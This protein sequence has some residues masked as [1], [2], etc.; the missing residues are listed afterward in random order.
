MT[1][2]DEHDFPNDESQDDPQQ[3]NLPED[4]QP[5]FMPEDNDETNPEIAS[6]IS[7]DAEQG[8]WLN[9]ALMDH[10]DD[11]APDSDEDDFVDMSGLSAPDDGYADDVPLEIHDDVDTPQLSPEPVV[12]IQASS[13]D[14]RSFEEL[15]LA[16]L[17]GQLLRAPRRTFRAVS[18]VILTP[19]WG[20]GRATFTSPQQPLSAPQ[21]P[22]VAT[23][24]RSVGFL[25]EV[26][27]PKTSTEIQR[28]DVQ[29][30]QPV[31]SAR[32]LIR[33][34][35]Y[36]IAF[37]LAW[38]G[39]NVF[40]SGGMMNRSESNQLAKGVPFLIVAFAIW[41]GAEAFYHWDGLRNW[42]ANWRSRETQD[43][44]IAPTENRFASYREDVP[45][46]RVALMSGA[47]IFA[48]LTWIGTSN[49]SFSFMGFWS[50]CISVFLIVLAMLPMDWTLPE[51]WT[52][53]R[54]A[55]K[56]P[57]VTV[58]PTLIAIVVI[59]CIGGYFRFNHFDSVPPEMTSD[60]VEKLLDSQR[61]VNGD[62]DVFFANNGGREPFQMY[63]MAILT[64][65]PGFEMDHASLKFLAILESLVT[66]PVLFWMGREIVG[67][68]DRQLGTVVGLI[69]MALVAVSYWHVSITRLALRI[70]LTPLVTALLMIYLSRAMRHNRRIDYILAGL[71]LGFGMYTYQAV[72]MLPVVVVV[73]VFL[74]LLF[75]AHSMRS[76][77]RYV[78]N[79]AALIF[80]SGV[81][82][83]PLGRFWYQYPEVF[84]QRTAGRL[85]GDDVI[86]EFDAE[87]N[88]ISERNATISERIDAFGANM[89]ALA[90]NVRT[91]L[92]MYNWKGDVAWIN[93][94]PNEPIMDPFT[95]GLLIIGLAAWLVL[96]I[97][98]RDTALLLI[99]IAVFIMLLPSALAIAAPIENPS[100][101]RTSGSLPEAYLIAALPLSLIAISMRR[102]FQNKIGGIVSVFM[103]SL[104][105]MGA[106]TVNSDRYFGNFQESY[107]NSSLPY[108]EAGRILRGFAESDGAYGNAYIVAYQFWW[109]HRAVGI[110]AGVIDWPNGIVSRED[111]PNFLYDEWRCSDNLYR[112]D[113]TRDLLFFYNQYD[114]ETESYLR[115][116]FPEGRATLINSYQDGD[117][118]YI[119]R[120]PPLTLDGMIEFD[121]EYVTERRC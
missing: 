60:H 28:E 117:D 52:R 108:T 118:F 74:A 82:F 4:I 87:G 95:G 91:A 37:A 120:A 29:T 94:A 10:A 62:R 86:Q 73:G 54:S 2:N 106:F 46:I 39:N 77:G 13:D 114:N 3:D 11:D 109:D 15:S 43:D 7:D 101:T 6:E 12:E 17:T 90:D 41:L 18:E 35:L 80:V 36:L 84:W 25:P 97:Q 102:A 30:Q 66:L 83:V 50:W 65:L 31:D 69:L 40:I 113:V 64:R 103:V 99:P 61:V 63:A 116:L 23:P 78:L 51:A 49:N 16:E 98:R 67:E 121:R 47:I 72:R 71:I 5:E 24:S 57:R 21:Q 70:V 92:L 119:F 110:D 107:L 45:L 75:R 9:A 100:A 104:V 42:F 96:L 8:E 111:I 76:R 19:V 14:D 1:T 34:S 81:V 38:Y 33:V 68:K 53:F 26:G 79:L 32:E 85:L 115:R 22:I 27:Y 105:V 48:G 89:S 58:T 93:G 59:M 20:S 44:D 88:V 55:F 56:M 112:L